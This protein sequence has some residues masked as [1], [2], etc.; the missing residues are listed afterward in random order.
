MIEQLKK[1]YSSFFRRK[2]GKCY[3][4]EFPHRI[5][6]EKPI[7]IGDYA[8]I[9]G[10]LGGQ[11]T[12]GADCY[13]G[14]FS[15]VATCGGNIKIGSRVQIGEMCVFTGQGG[16]TIGDD[17]LFADRVNIIANEHRYDDITRP[18]SLQGCY[19]KPVEIG[20]GSWFG[21]NVTVLHGVKIGKNCVIA[22]GSIVTRD[23]DDYS[24]VAGVP[25][26]VIRQYS[27]EQNIWIRK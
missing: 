27:T 24:V 17:V 13:V 19:S 14:R 1:I 25:A 16:I 21:I 15:K 3:I 12:F 23:I 6:I 7:S 22:A 26:R 9:S 4:F 2:M 20:S 5:K 10:Y 8:V 11:L 18:I